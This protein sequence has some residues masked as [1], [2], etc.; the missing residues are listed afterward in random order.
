LFFEQVKG[1]PN[2]QKGPAAVGAMIANAEQLDQTFGQ[3]ERMY[4]ALAAI[5]AEV[6]PV[7]PKLFALMAEGPM[8]DIRRLKAE[9]DDYTGFAQALELHSTFT[10]QRQPPGAPEP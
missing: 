2:L 8:E 9:I 10:D 3:L 6:L 1:K 5:R 7:N 4:R